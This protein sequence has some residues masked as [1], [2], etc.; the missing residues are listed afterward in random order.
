MDS[1]W[2]DPNSLIPITPPLAWQTAASVS[3]L[4]AIHQRTAAVPRSL[5]GYHVTSPG[6]TPAPARQRCEQ[7][8]PR[9]DRDITAAQLLWLWQCDMSVTCDDSVTCDTWHDPGWSGDAA[10]QVLERA[11]RC[12]GPGPRLRGWREHAQG[13][14]SRPPAAA[15]TMFIQTSSS[16]W[17]LTKT[18][19]KVK[20]IV[21]FWKL[22]R[23]H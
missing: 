17:T 13:T 22:A 23:W 3:G 20:S 7:S 6:G 1:P 16:L 21:F 15:F 11:E 5:S 19:R 10:D 2:H 9:Y 8:V 4:T 14:Q 12:A 18:V